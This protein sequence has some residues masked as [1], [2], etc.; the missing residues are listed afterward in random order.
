MIHRVWTTLVCRFAGLRCSRSRPASR[1]LIR[2]MKQRGRRIDVQTFDIR[3]QRI[4]TERG[5]PVTRTI[6]GNE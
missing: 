4:A 6:R 5:D 2:E 3:K 1:D